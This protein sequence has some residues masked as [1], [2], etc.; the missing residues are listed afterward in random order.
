MSLAYEA[1]Q[2]SCKGA[3]LKAM[4]GR[5]NAAAL[6]AS[7]AVVWLILDM[8]SKAYFNSGQFA[9][10]QFIAG[11]FCGLF[12]F[13]LVHNTGAAWGIFGDSTFALGVFSLVMCI[14]ILGVFIYLSKD[15][16]WVETLGIALVFSGGIGNAIDRFNLSYVVDFINLSFMDFPVFN[17]ADIGVTCG[18]VIFL[19][20]FFV[21]EFSAAKESESC[22]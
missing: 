16:S 15:I 3:R 13:T 20:A 4:K 11:P 9:L 10:G 6:F 14:A 1:Q 19:V 22:E 17:I 21:R 2:N 12:E 8:A 7:A 5:R 18:I